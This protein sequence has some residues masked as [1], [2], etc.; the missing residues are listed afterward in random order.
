MRVKKRRRS[1]KLAAA[2]GARARLAAEVHVAREEHQAL[3][4]EIEL[5]SRS[6]E[7]GH[8]ALRT[9]QAHADSKDALCSQLL[10]ERHKA[11]ALATALRDEKSAI[12]EKLA[13]AEV[14]AAAR[15]GAR[16]PSDELWP[17][18][19]GPSELMCRPRPPVR[20]GARLRLR[21]RVRVRV[22]PSFALRAR[23]VRVHARSPPSRS[24]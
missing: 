6:Y 17:S 15:T 21:L 8:E 14:R 7:E 18:T 10:A 3:L 11:A 2:E 5:I 1:H 22:C 4:S 9:L 24:A 16:P 23:H 13:A 12:V 20:G 19:R